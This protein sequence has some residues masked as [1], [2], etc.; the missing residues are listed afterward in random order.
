MITTETEYVNLKTPSAHSSVMLNKYVLI[1][2]EDDSFA[3]LVKPQGITFDQLNSQAM[4]LLS[5][6]SPTPTSNSS[7]E[8]EEVQE[9]LRRPH[10]AHRLDVD[11]G[12]LICVAKTKLALQRLSDMFGQRE[13]SK[14]YIALVIGKQSF[15][16]AN[17]NSNSNSNSAH[18]DTRDSSHDGIDDIDHIKTTGI[19]DFDLD[20]KSAITHW[21]QLR[22]DTVDSVVTL[23]GNTG[24]V[25][26]DRTKRVV[27]TLLL[28]P[29][30]GRN[31]QLRRHL[32]QSG[33]PI[34]GDSKYGPTPVSTPES[35]SESVSE[36]PT[37][38]KPIAFKYKYKYLALW[39]TRLVFEHPC[40]PGTQVDV[41]LPEECLATGE[42]GEDGEGGE[43][44][45]GGE[46]EPSY[47]AAL[48]SSILLS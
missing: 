45:M 43:G 9:V 44:G 21:E 25:G 14:E 40:R 16:C 19:I 12:G 23:G 47:I 33:F 2:Y 38:N 39:S 1:A 34:I 18:A 6:P 3:V 7:R 13:I 4:L 17:A 8:V 26:A 48:R 29:S 37:G 15:S 5:P 22:S 10:A 32:K 42:D 20:G 27:S 30:T 46:G 28:M 35:V 31:H 11:T 36:V 41:R 24:T